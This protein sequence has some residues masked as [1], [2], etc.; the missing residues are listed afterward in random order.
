MYTSTS[1]IFLTILINSRWDTFNLSEKS[2][3]EARESLRKSFD[4]MTQVLG[5]EPSSVRGR[6]SEGVLAG[7]ERVFPLG[8]RLRLIG[9]TASLEILFERYGSDKQNA[10]QQVLKMVEPGTILSF[11]SESKHN[12]SELLAMLFRE[13]RRLLYEVLPVDRAL[14]L[15]DDRAIKKNY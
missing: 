5:I 7:R 1:P 13:L 14:L 9:S 11:S 2:A 8:N 10:V 3:K 15:P 12:S 4:T 6:F